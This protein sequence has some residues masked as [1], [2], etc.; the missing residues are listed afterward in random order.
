[1]IGQLTVPGLAGAVAVTFGAGIGLLLALSLLPGSREAARPLWV[2][3]GSEAVI[4]SGGVLPWFLPR[5]AILVWLLIGAGRIG[6][7][8]G[9]VYGLITQRRLAMVGACLLPCVALLGWL[10]DIK[11]LLV[12]VI[13]LLVTA[14]SL[15]RAQRGSPLMA[16]LARCLVFPLVPVMAFA[17]AAPQPQLAPLLILSLLLVEVFDSFSLLGGRLYGRTPLVPRLSPRKTWEGLATGAAALFAAALAI[18]Q[19]FGVSTASMLLAG[20]TVLICA[21][22]GDLLGSHA[23]RQAGVKDY[24]PVMT[25]QGGLLDIADSWI[26]AGPCVAALMTLV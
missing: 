18:A 21:M 8:S 10:M 24:P 14:A 5:E 26:V 25:V 1:M 17:H 16:V 11:A 7:E 3:L 15:A 2:L 20:L 19:V 13:A 22:A 23:K 6:Y 12:S 9:T 4:L